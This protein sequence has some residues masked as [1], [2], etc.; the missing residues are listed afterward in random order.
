MHVTEVRFRF[1]KVGTSDLYQT[2]DFDFVSD[3]FIRRIALK[4][5][6]DAAEIV[7]KRS[8][9][10]YEQVCFFRTPRVYLLLLHLSFVWLVEFN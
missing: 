9:N 8:A 5:N 1:R 3:N 4:I 6:T 7:Q 2:S 10:A